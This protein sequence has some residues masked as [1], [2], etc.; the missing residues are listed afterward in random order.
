MYAELQRYF[1][2]NPVEYSDEKIKAN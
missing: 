2:Q 1:H